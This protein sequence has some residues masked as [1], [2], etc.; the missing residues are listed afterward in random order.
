M[1][2]NSINLNH[3]E[4]VGEALDLTLNNKYP[5]IELLNVCS[6]LPV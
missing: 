6:Q 4:R 5:R 2:L 1:Y 3:V